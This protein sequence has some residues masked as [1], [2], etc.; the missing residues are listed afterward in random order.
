[1]IRIP[2]GGVRSLLPQRH[3]DRH[4][5]DGVK[6]S[7]PREL[8]RL[9]DA[10]EELVER[11]MAEWEMK[12][13]QGNP[14]WGEA[15]WP[16]TAFSSG[17]EEKDLLKGKVWEGLDTGQDF[18]GLF[19][20]EAEALQKLEA[21]SE[22]L[23]SFLESLE[24]GIVPQETW[25]EIEKGMLENERSKKSLTKEEERNWILEMLSSSSAHSTSLTLITFMLARV[26]NETAPV[27]KSLGS[28]RSSSEI[29][30]RSG[31]RIASQDLVRRNEVDGTL[32]A[33]FAKAMIRAPTITKE[34]ERKASELR[35]KAVVQL[36]TSAQLDDE[37]P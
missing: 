21:V 30:G 26:A 29:T 19:P 27:Q 25:M 32:A 33:I 11:S 22:V 18:R 17:G 15:G 24:D 28:P 36:F 3:G 9:T 13:E 2:E 35:R 5:S 8:F 34:K 4:G 23:L 6:W 12:S 1:M 14:P 7:A 37:M 31:A 10:I 16:F 20:L